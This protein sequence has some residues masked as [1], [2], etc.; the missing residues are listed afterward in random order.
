MGV[1]ESLARRAAMRVREIVLS[2]SSYS[3]YEDAPAT[4]TRLQMSGWRHHL[5]SNNYPELWQVVE[6]LGLSRFFEGLPPYPGGLVMKN[7]AASYLNTALEAAEYPDACVMIGGQFR[8]RIWPGP[9]R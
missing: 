1:E 5:L 2:A 6:K 7:H 3:P 8:T 9:R 4:L